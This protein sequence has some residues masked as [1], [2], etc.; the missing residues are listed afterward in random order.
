MHVTANRGIVESRFATLSAVTAVSVVQDGSFKVMDFNGSTSEITLANT[1]N[2][3][4]DRT[5]LT[6][7]KL[8]SLGESNLGAV[9][10]GAPSYLLCTTPNRFTLRGDNYSANNS[11]ELWKWFHLAITK[12]ADGKTSYYINSVLSGAAD[13]AGG[14]TSTGVGTNTYI[15]YRGDNDTLHLDGRMGDIQIWRGILTPAELSQIYTSE[16]KSF[17]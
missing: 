2:Y 7:L 15:G 13:Q 4:T 10:H 16:K 8:R 9:F 6:W 1:T 5:Y 3:G 14:L 12:K 11:I 17:I